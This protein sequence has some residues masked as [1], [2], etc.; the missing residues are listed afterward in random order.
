MRLLITGG[1]GYIGSIVAELAVAAGHSAVVIDDLRCG[2]R[3]AVPPACPLV[4]GSIGDSEALAGRRTPCRWYD[5]RACAVAGAS[6]NATAIA[7]TISAL[8][9]GFSV[10]G[11]TKPTDSLRSTARVYH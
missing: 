9:R 1:A 2:N 4:V 7:A 5:F 11:D 3:G 6:S 10:S 8:T